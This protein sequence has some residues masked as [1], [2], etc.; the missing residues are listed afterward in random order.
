MSNYR[1]TVREMMRDLKAAKSPAAA[2]SPSTESPTE[3][4]KVGTKSTSTTDTTG[5][6]PDMEEGTS[7]L[8]VPDEEELLD[9]ILDLEEGGP[10]HV[11][12][13][14]SEDPEAVKTSSTSPQ[15]PDE[16]EESE[17]VKEA[18]T[19]EPESTCKSLNNIYFLLFRLWY[20]LLNE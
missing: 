13:N 8:P 4:N 14:N 12:E 7:D 10:P 20:I 9:D 16:K 11:D 3:Q 19:P 5:S 2:P 17:T 15:V 18:T 6:N 1:D